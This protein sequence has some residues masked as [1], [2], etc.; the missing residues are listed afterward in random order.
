MAVLG[1]RRRCFERAQWAARSAL[2]PERHDGTHD[3][4]LHLRAR[5]R[6][7]RCF[8]G[9]QPNGGE[10]AVGAPFESL[11]VQGQGGHETTTPTMQSLC[12]S[13]FVRV[14]KHGGLESRSPIGE[15]AL[16]LLQKT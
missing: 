11:R 14:S 7:C 10:G 4:V 16:E 2:F 6:M 9:D 13:R 3:L 5:Y 8:C 1:R 15:P 12:T